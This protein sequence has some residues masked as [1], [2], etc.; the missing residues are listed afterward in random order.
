MAFFECVCAC[1]CACVKRVGLRW[2]GQ[3]GGGMHQVAFL[4]DASSP[5]LGAV[6]SVSISSVHTAPQ[7][8]LG[9]HVIVD[10]ALFHM[11]CGHHRADVSR[12]AELRDPGVNKLLQTVA[13]TK[14]AQYRD[15]YADRL[16]TTYSTPFLPAS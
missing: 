12:N 1:V 16:G 10:V 5:L 8:T 6:E 13:R 3:K 15:V 4:L 2:G 11:F 14:V 9:R 7:H